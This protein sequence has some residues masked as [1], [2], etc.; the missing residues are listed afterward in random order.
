[1]ITVHELIEEL[2][3]IPNQEAKVFVISQVHES[4]YGELNSIKCDGN[5]VYL[6]NE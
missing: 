1:M 6:D 5:E 3:K 2:L 4:S